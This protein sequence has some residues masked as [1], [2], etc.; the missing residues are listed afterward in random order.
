MLVNISNFAEFLGWF[1]IV[2]FSVGQRQVHA[3]P[4]LGNDFSLAKPQSRSLSISNDLITSLPGLETPANF[5]QYSGYISVDPDKN[6]RLFYWYVESQNNPR[7]DPVILWL[8]GGPGCSSVADLLGELGPFYVQSDSTLAVNKYSW[9]RIANVLFLEMPAGVGFSKSDP[10]EHN[11]DKTTNNSLTFLV[12]FFKLYPH[13][14]SLPFWITGESYAGHYIPILATKVLQHND[15]LHFGEERI[16]LQGLMLDNP[17]TDFQIDAGGTVDSAYSRQLISEE[18]HKALRDFCNYTFPGLSQNR[19]TLNAEKCLLYEAKVSQEMGN[20]NKYNI[21]VDVCLNKSENHFPSKNDNIESP[22]FACQE[23]YIINYL[24]RPDVQKAI[25]AESTDWTVC[26]GYVQSKYSKQ[27]FLASMIPYYKNNLL[28]H[29]LKI[30]IF[31]GDVDSLVPPTSTRR[32]LPL[33]GLKVKETWKPW[34]D[35]NHQVGGYAVVYKGLTFTTVRNAGHEAAT[36]QSLRAYD[37]F[38]RFLFT[39]S[40]SSPQH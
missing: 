16:N 8:N 10:I 32:W 35:S 38:S 36:Y 15:K 19:S 14:K 30:L 40:L 24:N 7:K 4:N 21:Y 27:D 20:I 22:Y 11:D 37:V 17:L 28:K 1:G 13:L 9:N 18:T 33:L 29:G 6:S 2:L 23:N 25:H 12:E 39:G 31:S 3:Q 34:L 26:S 5:K